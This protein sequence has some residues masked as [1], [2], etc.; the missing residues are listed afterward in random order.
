[1]AGM[2]ESRGAA[3]RNVR[4]CC[5]NG[6]IWHQATGCAQYGSDRS[7]VWCVQRLPLDT[8]C[9]CQYLTK[10]FLVKP[11]VFMLFY[12]GICLLFDTM[13][14][15]LLFNNILML[16]FCSGKFMFNFESISY[17]DL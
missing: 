4:E 13:R 7:G 3:M 11:L 6:S 2:R 5:A 10:L 12:D 15:Q 1:M 8:F 17:G 9:A 14:W 16:C